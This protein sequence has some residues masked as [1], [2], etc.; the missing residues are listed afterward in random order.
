MIEFPTN[1]DTRVRGVKVFRRCI[2][3][4]MVVKATRKD[5]QVGLS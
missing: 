1:I 4:G 2:H 3:R 5:N